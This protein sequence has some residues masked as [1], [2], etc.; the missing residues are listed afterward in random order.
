M[1]IWRW[2]YLCGHHNELRISGIQS[3]NR[4]MTTRTARLTRFCGPCLADMAATAG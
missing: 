2:E 3:E 4:M 1:I